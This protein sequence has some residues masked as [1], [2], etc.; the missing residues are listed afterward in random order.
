MELIIILN[1]LTKLVVRVVQPELQVLQE[2]QD[3]DMMAQIQED[4]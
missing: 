2:H 3:L 1:G 4:G